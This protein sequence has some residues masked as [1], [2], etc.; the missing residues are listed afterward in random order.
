MKDPKVTEIVKQF[1]K[2]VA[3]LNKTWAELQKYDVYARVNIKGSNSYTEPKYI[4][5]TEITQ[6]VQ[7]MKEEK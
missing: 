6:S 4:E 5:V 2:D 3:T 1:H 7:Y